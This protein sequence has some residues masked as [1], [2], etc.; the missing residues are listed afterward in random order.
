MADPG[1]VAQ[2]RVW[3]ESNPRVLVRRPLPPCTMLGGTHPLTLQHC[4]GGEGDAAVGRVCTSKS[5][6]G[7]RH[8]GAAANP[9]EGPP[10]F[11]TGR[12][13]RTTRARPPTLQQLCATPNHPGPLLIIAKQCRRGKRS[14]GLARRP[15]HHQGRAKV[16]NADVR[17]DKVGRRKRK[18]GKCKHKVAQS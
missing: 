14:L 5:K 1:H 10:F 2:D 15:R 18:V 8:A 16:E 17:K 11:S 3:V 4:A 6:I 7:P 12:D 13:I 9:C